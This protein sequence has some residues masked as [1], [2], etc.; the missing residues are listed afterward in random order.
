HFNRKSK[1]KTCMKD[2]TLSFLKTI[3]FIV[4]G[5]LGVI[6]VQSALEILFSGIPLH[7][8]D[9]LTPAEAGSLLNVLR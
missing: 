7:R 8:L 2:N 5:A 3:L 4:A 1:E 6:F 9:S